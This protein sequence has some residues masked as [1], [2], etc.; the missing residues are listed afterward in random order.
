MLCSAVPAGLG[1]VPA[2]FK[3]DLGK[4]AATGTCWVFG[5]PHY[6]TFDG[7]HYDFM[8]NCTYT[9]A[10]NCH[11]DGQPPAFEVEVRN[12]NHPKSETPAVE[13]VIIKVYDYTFTIY[14]DEFG[15]VRVSGID[16]LIIITW[17]YYCRV[18]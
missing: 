17:H 15:L 5:D 13:M 16:V 8:G 2:P 7:S 11:E 14:R 3:L 12:E 6:R 9:M 1:S 4:D 10:K 18:H